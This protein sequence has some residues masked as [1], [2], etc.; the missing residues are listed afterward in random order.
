MNLWSGVGLCNGATGLEPAV[1]LA[2]GARV[3]LTMNLRSGVGLCNGATGTVI[4]F[5]F[6]RNHQ[7][8]ELP[9]AVIVQIEVPNLMRRKHLMS[10]YA[11]SLFHCSQMMVSTRDNNYLLDLLGL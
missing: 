11:Q 4:D 10:Q 7:P 3:M 2:K 1:F 9:V 6:E 8:P 5:I